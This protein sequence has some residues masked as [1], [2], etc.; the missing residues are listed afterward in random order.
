MTDVDASDPDGGQ[1][2]SYALSGVDAGRF[3][4]SASTGALAFAAA[5]DREAPTDANGDNVY[6]VTVTVSDGAGG[7]D[8]QAL[9]VTVSNVNEAPISDADGPDA[10]V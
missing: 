4:L 3:T 7:S 8:A 1:V 9:S 10:A 2:L 6:E 5:P